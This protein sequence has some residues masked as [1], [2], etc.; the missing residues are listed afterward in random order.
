MID[1]HSHIL[2][3]VDDGAKDH[4][5]TIKMAKAAV[6]NGITKII[7]TP[8]HQNGVYNNDGTKIIKLVL[9]LNEILQRES[10]SLEVLPGQESQFY[11]G[12]VDD[13][14]LGKI[15]P[16]NNS[17]YI[18][19]E[20]PYNEIPRYAE[21][22]LFDISSLGYIPIIPHPERNSA[23]RENPNK[24]YQLVKHGALTQITSGSLLGH[25]GKEV[26]NFSYKILKAN[27]THFVATDAHSASGKRGFN[28]REAYKMIETRLGKEMVSYLQDN[29]EKLVK[30]TIIY[31]E[32]PEKIS[33]RKRFF[34]L[35]G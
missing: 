3:A 35:I 27:L 11:V 31:T 7:A 28:L 18:F 13:L 5:E 25:F 14:I 15:L 23:I 6:E 8:H 10:I 33:E 32:P 29:A 12:Y 26:E 1:I 34:G 9:E 4:I 17:Y 24:L 20:F 30:N 19:V 22:L 2:S 21:K 16:L